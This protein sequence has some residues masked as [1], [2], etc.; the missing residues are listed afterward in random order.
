[1]SVHLHHSPAVLVLACTHD[2]AADAGLFS[3]NLGSATMFPRDDESGLQAVMRVRPD[4]VMMEAGR[5]EL[6]SEGFRE[7]A[8]SLGAT[9]MVFGGDKYAVREIARRLDIAVVAVQGEA[10]A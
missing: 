2:S 10:Q 7:L 1:M 4:V 9:V 6:T 3:W 8:R 5:P